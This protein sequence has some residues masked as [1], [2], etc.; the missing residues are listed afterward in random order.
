[1]PINPG[2]SLANDVFIADSD[3]AIHRELSRRAHELARHPF[4]VGLAEDLYSPAVVAWAYRRRKAIHDTF[5]PLLSQ[6][7]ST[8]EAAGR[9]ELRTALAEN[10]SDEN[11]VNSCTGLPTGRGSHHQWGQWFMAALN[12]LDP[13]ETSAC[14]LSIM[15]FPVWNP[16]P[17][18]SDDS[19][20]LRVG[21]LM[22]TE[23]IIPIE[24]R[25]FLTAFISAFPALEDKTRP[26]LLLLFVDHIEHDEKR[27]IPD[28]I[29]GFLGHLP[30]SKGYAVNVNESHL[31]EARDLLTGM[32]R[33]FSARMQFYDHLSALISDVP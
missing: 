25:A 29:D 5:M 6:A 10:L 32:D 2:P 11:G 4:M 1:M 23:K 28:L 9:P 16:Y 26:E 7:I 19:L 8:A 27:H 17:T 22:A 30:G 21:M 33:V 20:A 13:L 3:N 31:M 15:G 24:Y 18:T 12:D 14:E